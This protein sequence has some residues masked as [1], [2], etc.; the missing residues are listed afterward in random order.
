[1]WSSRKVMLVTLGPRT[2]TS[3][4]KAKIESI[5]TD[6]FLRQI[7]KSL[8]QEMLGAWG[9]GGTETTLKVR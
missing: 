6:R 4:A 2:P 3:Y 5:S 9:A 7:G 1:M 8:G